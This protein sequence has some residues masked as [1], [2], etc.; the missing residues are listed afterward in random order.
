MKTSEMKKVAKKAE[1]DMHK[2]HEKHLHEK[3]KKMK[4]PQVKGYK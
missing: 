4:M 1:S 2:K 3:P